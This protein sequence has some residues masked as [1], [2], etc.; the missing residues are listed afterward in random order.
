[1]GRK[2]NDIAAQGDADV[3]LFE[4]LRH[5]AG[6]QGAFA[7]LV[8]RYRA[9]VYSYLARCGIDPADRDDL[10]QDPQWR[11][12][13]RFKDGQ[14][15]AA[16][17]SYAAMEG[18]DAA[19]GEG[20]ARLRNRQY[21]PGMRAFERALE[22]QPDFDAARHNLEVAT[23]MVKLVEETQAQSDTGEEAGIGADEIVFVTHDAGVVAV[24]EVKGDGAFRTML[25]RMAEWARRHD[26]DGPIHLGQRLGQRVPVLLVR[27]EAQGRRL[28]ARGARMGEREL[29]DPRLAHQLRARALDELA[30][31]GYWRIG[32]AGEAEATLADSLSSGPLAIVLGA[33]G[34]GMRQNIA[35]HCDTL[36]RLPITSDIESLN[37]SNAAAI[38]LYAVATRST[39]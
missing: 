5:I 38:A 4:L 3:G 12:Y 22:L 10:F 15:E 34:E 19:F 27:A 2:A 23:A 28:A 17:E 36:S 13:A 8:S 26:D 37:V 20:M 7:E 25:E 35:G 21:R 29:A 1:M 39:Q 33:E 30:E 16:A 18:A 9:P 14:Y 32:L 11:A 31:S 24:A 6:E